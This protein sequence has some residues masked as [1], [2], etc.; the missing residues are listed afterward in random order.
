MSKL[1]GMNVSLPSG[2]A[3]GIPYA[4]V[5]SCSCISPI[6][7]VTSTTLCMHVPR[8]SFYCHV[9]MHVV[10]HVSFYCRVYM[11]VPHVSF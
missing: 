9:C 6:H 10:L 2:Q 8:M 1:S 11:H 5:V 4:I 3:V 7:V